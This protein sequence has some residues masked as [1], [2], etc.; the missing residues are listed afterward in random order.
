MKVV[1]GF[2]VDQEEN[3]QLNVINHMRQG[4]RNFARQEIITRKDDG[5]LFRYTYKDSYERMQRLANA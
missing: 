2:I 4:I 1:K 3:H 5:T